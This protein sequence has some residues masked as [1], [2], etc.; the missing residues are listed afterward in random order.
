MNF[1][2]LC[3][4]KRRAAELRISEHS[5]RG[6]VVRA[7][8]SLAAARRARI[9]ATPFHD[10]LDAARVKFDAIYDALDAVEYSIAYPHLKG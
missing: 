2:E 4:A 3:D 9:N 6:A 8:L 10:A 1:Q 7:I 5:A